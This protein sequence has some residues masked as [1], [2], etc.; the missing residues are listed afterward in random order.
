MIQKVGL[1]KP[2]PHSN[3][4]SRRGLRIDKTASPECLEPTV[5]GQRQSTE[6][7]TEVDETKFFTPHIRQVAP[8]VIFLHFLC[9][10]RG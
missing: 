8:A 7:C 3:L 10:T 4:L 1:Q 2:R 6:T 9:D 5:Q